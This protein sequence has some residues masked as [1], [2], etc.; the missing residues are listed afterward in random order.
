MLDRDQLVVPY[1]PPPAPRVHMVFAVISVLTAV[2]STFLLLVADYSATV[3]IWLLLGIVAGSFVAIVL[4]V[5]GFR[6]R[7]RF[8]DEME[9]AVDVTPVRPKIEAPRRASRQA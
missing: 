8:R 5:V 1:T 3:T 7:R 6:A 9:R 4:L 2:T